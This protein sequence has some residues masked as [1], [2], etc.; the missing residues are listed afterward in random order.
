MAILTEKEYEVTKR[1]QANFQK[2][3]DEL[4]AMAGPRPTLAQSADINSAQSMADEL[5]AE[6]DEWE[7]EHGS[8]R[9]SMEADSAVPGQTPAGRDND[10]S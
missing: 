5:Q 7:K 3:A 6:I 8:E 10:R 9:G 4:R 2:Q 1:W